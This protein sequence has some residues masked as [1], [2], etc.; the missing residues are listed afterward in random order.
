MSK[1]ILGLDGLYFIGGV[2]LLFSIATNLI[3]RKLG[4]KKRTAELRKEVDSYQ[5]DFKAASEKNDAKELESL[6]VREPQMMKA[7]QEM[8]FLPFKNMIFVVPLFFVVIWFVTSNYHGFTVNIPIGIHP[9]EILSL[10]VFHES[11]YGPRGY[12][13]FVSIFAGLAVEFMLNNL[14][15]TLNKDGKKKV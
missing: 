1:M 8:M 14:M 13:I 4:I 3:G 10:N 11:T 15:D 5:K 2:A 7:M 6:K 9:G 12:F